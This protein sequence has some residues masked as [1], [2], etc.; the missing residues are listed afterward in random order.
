M[1]VIVDFSAAMHF[2]HPYEVGGLYFT[3]N[4]FLPLLGLTFMLA[5][6][7]AKDTIEKA[8]LELL[9]KVSVALGIVLVV[10]VALFLLL[11][12]KEYHHTFFSLETGGQMTRRVFLEG[13]DV[14]KKGVFS[15]HRSHWWPLKDKV[16]IWVKEGWATWEE[17]KP[18]WFT[19][20]WK[21][22]VPKDMIPAKRKDDY[23]KAIDEDKTPWLSGEESSSR[24]KG[25]VALI[26]GQPT[27]S[28]KVSPAE[29]MTDFDEEE[30]VRQMDRH[31]V[32]APMGM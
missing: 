25:I 18:D 30:F 2:R 9:T 29:G 19:D 32:S 5:L 16:A 28:S 14:S 22:K 20:A 23:Y 4:L 17:E 13:E 10:L 1:K 7:L 3:L 26:G 12:N 21:A 6:D 8:T 24:K 11:M 27:A 15:L 31:G